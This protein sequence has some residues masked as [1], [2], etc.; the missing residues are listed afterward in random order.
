MGGSG[1]YL[2]AAHTYSENQRDGREIWKRYSYITKLFLNEL[3]LELQQRC[4]AVI[5]QIIY[6]ISKTAGG[7]V[8]PESNSFNCSYRSEVSRRLILYLKN[9]RHSHMCIWLLS[10]ARF[11]G[12]PATSR[13]SC[14]AE[15]FLL[16]FRRRKW[17]ALHHDDAA[18]IASLQ[19]GSCRACTE[20]KTA[21]SPEM[22]KDGK[23]HGKP[24]RPNGFSREFSI[25]LHFRPIFKPFLPL[26]FLERGEKTPTPK[27]SALLRKRPVLLTAN[28]VL[29]KD[30]KRPYY[31]H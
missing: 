7:G 16:F 5:F 26:V 2:S 30:R 3:K 8:N 15:F 12:F 10:R 13:V 23:P 1:L 24:P 31:G 22:G 18:Q 21:R 4:V 14:D 9:L 20:W 27:I 11:S 19:L 28:F 6:V 17:P 29:T 25:F